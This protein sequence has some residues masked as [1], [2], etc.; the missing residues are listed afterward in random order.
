MIDYIETLLGEGNLLV[1]LLVGAVGSLLS[2]VLLKVLKIVAPSLVSLLVS[3]SNRFIQFFLR[4]VV[5]EQARLMSE[6]DTN[7]IVSYYAGQKASMQMYMFLALC[8]LLIILNGSIDVNSDLIIVLGFLYFYFF[9]SMVKKFLNVVLPNLVD[10]GTY[11]KKYIEF[12][13]EDKISLD[14]MIAELSENE[15]ESGSVFQKSLITEYLDKA[16]LVLNFMPS[17][18]R[19]VLSD[20]FHKTD[21]LLLSASNKARLGKEFKALVDAGEIN[22][23][24]SLDKKGSVTEYRIDN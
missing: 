24:V 4:S 10:I 2:V 13:G 7:K 17:G 20:L 1:V 18:S 19:F 21:W 6:M 8:A 5:I 3:I 14:E 9:M 11:K 23:V 22:C 15:N 12:K 16:Q